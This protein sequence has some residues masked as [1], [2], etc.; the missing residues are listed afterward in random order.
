M[1]PDFGRLPARGEVR[2]Y[3]TV[4]RLYSFRSSSVKPF[5]YRPFGYRCNPDQRSLQVI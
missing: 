3:R 4:N 1:L 2:L 5:G